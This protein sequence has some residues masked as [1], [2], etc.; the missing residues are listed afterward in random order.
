MSRHARLAEQV[1]ERLRGGTIPLGLQ[2][3]GY[4]PVMGHRVFGTELSDLLDDRI[5]GLSASGTPQSDD[6]AVHRAHAQAVLSHARVLPALIPLALSHGVRERR[7]A[8]VIAHDAE[9]VG[10]GELVFLTGCAGVR[11]TQER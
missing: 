7:G 5:E 10:V 9:D 6:Q 1:G 3:H 8:S 2:R 4:S 11:L